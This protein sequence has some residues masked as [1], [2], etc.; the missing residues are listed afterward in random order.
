MDLSSRVSRSGQ[1]VVSELEGKSVLL[2]IETNKYFSFDSV[3]IDIFNKITES[4]KTVERV[5]SEI[6]DEY[7]VSKQELMSDLFELFNQFLEAGLIE[8]E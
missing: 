8:V 3:A 2:D 4:P 6:L 5:A 7:D 1:F